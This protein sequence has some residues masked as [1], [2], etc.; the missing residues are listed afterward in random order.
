MRQF[1][2]EL[3]YWRWLIRTEVVADPSVVRSRAAREE[4]ASGVE[5]TPTP[6]RTNTTT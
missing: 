3:T 4:L 2:E 6:S 5:E 1:L